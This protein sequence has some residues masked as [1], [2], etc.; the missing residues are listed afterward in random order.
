MKIETTYT[1]KH[2]DVMQIVCDH[3]NQKLGLE[4]EPKDLKLDVTEYRY[5]EGYG[6]SRGDQQ[7]RINRIWFTT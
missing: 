3:V 5:D 6:S 7:A 4:L 2:E 1:L